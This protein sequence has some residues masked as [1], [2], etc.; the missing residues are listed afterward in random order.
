MWTL[1]SL[2]TEIDDGYMDWRVGEYMGKAIQNFKIWES[3]PMFSQKN[4]SDFLS[5]R[6]ILR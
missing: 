1:M 3:Q 5:G 4:S 2:L 6:K